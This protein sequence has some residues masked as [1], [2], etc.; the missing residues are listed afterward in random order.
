L[1]CRMTQG[2]P[3]QSFHNLVRNHPH[4]HDAKGAIALLLRTVED[5]LHER[6]IDIGLW[7]VIFWA[8]PM[9]SDVCPGQ[10]TRG[11]H[12]RAIAFQSQRGTHLSVPCS[13]KIGCLS[14]APDPSVAKRGLNHSQDVMDLGGGSDVLPARSV[15]DGQSAWAFERKMN[16]KGLSASPPPE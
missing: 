15:R 1:L 16:L 11:D 8:E 10:V 12:S 14:T 5:L 9:R 3:V 6:W 4:G 13:A 2:S 7:T